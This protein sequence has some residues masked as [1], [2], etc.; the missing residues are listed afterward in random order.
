MA[1]PR[2]MEA[3]G[4][5]SSH[6]QRAFRHP[7]ARAARADIHRPA[8][9]CRQ[10]TPTN[11]APTPMTGRLRQRRMRG[12]AG[13]SPASLPA[14]LRGSGMSRHSLKAHAYGG[15]SA[16]GGGDRRKLLIR[17]RQLHGLF[18]QCRYGRCWYGDL[19]NLTLHFRLFECRSRR[20]FSSLSGKSLN[21]PD[22]GHN[23]TA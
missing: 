6:R 17:R 9:H 18:R 10:G 3:A 15:R 14:A 19:N 5:S 22:C 12:T 16:A 8:R 13:L 7:Y 11:S 20:I 4:F 2:Q 21:I 1:G 23:S